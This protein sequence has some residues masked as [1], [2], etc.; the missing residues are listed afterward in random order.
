M[1]RQVEG[2]IELE[3][4]TNVHRTQNMVQ[5]GNGGHKRRDQVNLV[6]DNG[7]DVAVE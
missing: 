7:I 6:I 5:A 3:M 2:K 4:I 1:A